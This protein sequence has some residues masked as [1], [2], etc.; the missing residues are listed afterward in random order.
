MARRKYPQQPN[1]FD[2]VD[3]WMHCDLLQDAGAPARLWRR[4]RRIGDALANDPRLYFLA[5]NAFTIPRTVCEPARAI[6]DRKR[7]F[8][9]MPVFIR[10]ED[11]DYC[12]LESTPPDGPNEP[13]FLAAWVPGLE[14]CLVT[15]QAA[16]GR[17]D[18]VGRLWDYACR[19]WGGSRMKA[20]FMYVLGLTRMQ[21]EF[22]CLLPW[23]V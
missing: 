13:D 16:A 7:W 19:T 6:L 17:G 4:S 22:D 23:K 1:S 15:P 3:W 14:H 8:C 18:G 10:Q 2:P 11:I 9:S 5:V 20:E 12:R 21:T